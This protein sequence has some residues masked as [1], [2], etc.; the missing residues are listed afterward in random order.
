M[1]NSRPYRSRSPL[2]RSPK[3]QD[4][5]LDGDRAANNNF[6][7]NIW[8]YVQGCDENSEQVVQNVQGPLRL[9]AVSDVPLIFPEAPLMHFLDPGALKY[10]T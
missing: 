6:A 4:I 5:V 7:L 8:S 10:P 3:C 9:S 2:G 1:I